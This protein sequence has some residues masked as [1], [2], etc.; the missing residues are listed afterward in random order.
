MF[1]LLISL[2]LNLHFSD[3]NLAHNLPYLLWR[4][5]ILF[6]EMYDLWSLLVPSC[7]RSHV[8]SS[9][10]QVIVTFVLVLNLLKPSGNFTYHQV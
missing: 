1:P 5:F 7:F 6:R 2:A 9:I 10:L 4:N 3:L 8:A